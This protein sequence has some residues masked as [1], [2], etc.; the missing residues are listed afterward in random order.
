MISARKKYLESVRGVAALIVVFTHYCGAFYP[1]T[2]FGSKGVYTQH[3]AWEFWFLA[4]PMSLVLAG[5][6]AV[7]M[8][9][10]LSG[11]VL[12]YNFVG[13]SQ[14]RSAIIGSLVKRP[15]RLGGLVVL[16]EI[17]A[18]ILWGNNLFLNEQVSG[19]TTSQPWFSR[20]WVGQFDIS[21]WLSDVLLSPFAAAPRYNS[22]LWSIATEWY[23]SV[24]V[25][26]FLLLFAS[27]K[28][29][30]WVCI[31]L[32]IWFKKSYYV[33]FFAGVMLADLKVNH[34]DYY[35]IFRARGMT[36]VLLVAGLYL[37]SY[38][39]YADTSM[40]T[41]TMYGW[42][43]RL[44]GHSMLG[45]LIVF[46][47]IDS[48]PRIQFYLESRCL[49][50]LGKLSYAV[51]AIHFIVLGSFSSW[52]FLLLYNRLGYGAAFAAV[53]V[54]SLTLI[55][56]LAYLVTRFVDEPVIRASGV[57]GRVVNNFSG[58]FF[59][60]RAS[61]ENKAGVIFSDCEAEGRVKS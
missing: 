15:F 44:T 28:Y 52:L 53:S 58:R 20:N 24:L 46:V 49:V 60:T 21:N 36:I 56:T 17:I 37:S 47:L 54:A 3:S 18:A 43:P 35:G 19:I 34:Y 7:C 59:E 31:A 11:Y 40:L 45:A 33:G 10:I 32:M 4:S 2:L 26:I 1:F 57:I 27:N 42:F 22:P 38:P 48:H 51:Y 29:R 16:T 55:L 14:N 41:G 13:K 5:E 12:S 8:F 50:L 39:H 6:F 30:A 25:F 23:G 61:G 9:F